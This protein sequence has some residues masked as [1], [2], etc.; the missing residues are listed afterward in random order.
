MQIT[1]QKEAELLSVMHILRIN[2]QLAL[3][4]TDSTIIKRVRT[5]EY[6]I[7]KRLLCYLNLLL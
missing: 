2:V 6:F 7:A 3:A 4:Y 5:A 1:M